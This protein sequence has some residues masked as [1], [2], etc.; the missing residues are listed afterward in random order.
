MRQSIPD[1][2]AKEMD[3]CGGLPKLLREQPTKKALKDASKKFSTLSK[4]VRLRVLLLLRHGEL[5]VCIIK[6]AVAYPD[7]KLSYHLAC[8]KRAGLIRSRR[9]HSYLR[10]SLTDEGTAVADEI[11]RMLH[12]R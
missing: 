3:S 11:L 2:I 1:E 9:D 8:L 5:C 7:S 4:P 10:Y 6:R 12:D